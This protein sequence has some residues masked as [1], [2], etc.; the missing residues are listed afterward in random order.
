MIG[1]DIMCSGTTNNLGLPHYEASDHP[2]F[3]SE[4][5][6]AFKKLDEVIFDL[7]KREAAHVL[8]IENLTDEVGQLKKSIAELS[9]LV[10]NN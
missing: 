8:E 7:Q 1:G 3:L 4:I 9:K 2:D 10:A 5:N 6:D